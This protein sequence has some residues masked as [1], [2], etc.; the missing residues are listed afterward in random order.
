MSSQLCAAGK[1]GVVVVDEQTL[2]ALVGPTLARLLLQS[3][4]G[5]AYPLRVSDVV[6]DSG[7]RSGGFTFA[8]ENFSQR[9]EERVLS[10][11]VEIGGFE[12]RLQ[13]YPKGNNVGVGTHLSGEWHGERVTALASTFAATIQLL[14]QRRPCPAVYLEL[15]VEAAAEAVAWFIITLAQERARPDFLRFT[16]TK[17]ATRRGSRKL[18]RLARLQPSSPDLADDVLRVRVWL[19]ASSTV[20]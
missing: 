13:I 19:C 3:H 17:T 9:G 18:A 1:R 10:P 2:E 4:Y 14:E 8:V 11:W 20:A 12:W 15:N 7:H 6:I 16:F 5:S